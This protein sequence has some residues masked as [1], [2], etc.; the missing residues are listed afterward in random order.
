MISGTL[1]PY[2]E[3]SLSVMQAIIQQLVRKTKNGETLRLASGRASQRG[4][5]R[6]RLSRGDAA[7]PVQ[8]DGLQRQG[9]KRRAGGRVRRA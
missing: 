8:L 1:N 3:Y 4:V 9:H 2:E 7:R 6:P 5:A